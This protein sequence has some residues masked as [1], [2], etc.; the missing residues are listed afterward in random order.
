MVD[1]PTIQSSIFVERAGVMHCHLCKLVTRQCI[2]INL[3][4]KLRV[5]LSVVSMAM[6]EFKC[7]HFKDWTLYQASLNCQ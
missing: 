5:A 1:N 7:H 4:I 6:N 2:V 3:K